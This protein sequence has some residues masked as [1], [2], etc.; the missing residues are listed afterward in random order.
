VLLVTAG[1]DRGRTDRGA[2]GVMIAAFSLFLFLACYSITHCLS[3]RDVYFRGTGW[4]TRFTSAS[5]LAHY[6]GDRVS[7]GA[8]YAHPR[9][10]GANSTA[11]GDCALDVSD[12]ALFSVTA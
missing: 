12:M 9:L 10:G 3:W 2:F 4:F 11:P 8:D 1:A 7:D 5:L 6:S